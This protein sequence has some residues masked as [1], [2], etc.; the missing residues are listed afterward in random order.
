M[1][2]IEFFDKNF[3]EN[4]CACL[5]NVP[6]KMIIVG[7][8]GKQIEK[9]IEI[10]KEIFFDR[11]YD[12]EI[13]PQVVCRN[14]ITEITKALSEIVETYKDCTFDVTGGEDLYLVATG[15]IYEKYKDHEDKNI[16]IHRYNVMNNV[17][18]D[19]DMG[20]SQKITR[21][22]S[23]SVIENIKIF[24]GQI[25]YAPGI[26]DGTY[27]WDLNE[28][29]KKDIEAIWN[30]CKSHVTWNKEITTLSC[31]E[32]RNCNKESATLIES[33][34]EWIKEELKE[35]KESK[36]Y[37]VNGKAVKKLIK[38]GFIT[39]Y[40]CDGAWLRVEFKNEQIKRCL[41]KAGLALELKVYLSCL[42]AKSEDKITP[43]YNDAANG[44]YIDWD[45][46]MASN[47][48]DTSNEIDVM[49][50]YGMIPI[51]IS[52]KNGR[53]STD[54]LYKLNTV[55][56]RFGGRYAKKVLVI[57]QINKEDKSSQ[58]L[59]CRARDMGIHLITNFK[60]MS[61]DI[62]KREIGKLPLIQL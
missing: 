15:M 24:G 6:E 62:I 33:K 38:E 12:I 30:I 39:R 16:Q 17:L 23:L 32:E 25:M 1:T 9:N 29:F 44:V 41:T 36:E 22:P 13:I 59:I 26:K 40:E 4:L 8:S 52:C 48:I 46:E 45:G 54:E 56:E 58:Y 35:N 60:D 10:Y 53:V 21:A 34:I 28:E 2:H 11:G 55:A 31:A 47:D 57:S 14:D 51:F 27:I 18:Y 5:T 3:T 37:T 43:L 61:E 7:N 20:G 19:C 42:E 49:L 50:M